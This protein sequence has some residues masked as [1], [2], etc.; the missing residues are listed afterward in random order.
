MAYSGSWRTVN[1]LTTL[2]AQL[3][4]A[5][6]GRSHASDGFI[7]DDQHSTS[8]D[9]Y[10]HK[11]PALG[12]V[13][14][15]TAF[16]GTHDP[17]HGCDNRLVCEAIRQSRDPRVKYVISNGELFSG[18]ATSSRAAWTWG[19]YTG[20]S[21]PHRTHFHVS[22]VATAIADSTRPW[23]I[24]ADMALTPEERAELD[25]IQADCAAM[26]LGSVNSRNAQIYWLRSIAEGTAFTSPLGV[27]KPGIPQ[28]LAAINGLP[29]DLA[30]Q[31]AIALAA[32]PAFVNAIADQVAAAVGAKIGGVLTDILNT[33]TIAGTITVPE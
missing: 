27:G 24:G 5:F 32:N 8:S 28:V 33:A 4:K 18:Y 7:A 2:Q 14:V 21:D 1:S 10:P 30:A 25:A 3:D 29:V 15:V 12:A 26:I 17:A 23:S 16:D 11:Y 20:S 6:P 19:P 22:V 31:V 9:H 13:P